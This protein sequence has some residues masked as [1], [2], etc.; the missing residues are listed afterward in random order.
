MRIQFAS[1]AG[2]SPECHTENDLAARAAGDGGDEEDAVAFFDGAGF[3]AK[4]ANV[5][6]V[7]IDVEEL[8][9][10]AAVIA[11]VAREIREARSELRENFGDGGGATIDFWRAVSEA[12][13]RGG[14]FY[15]DWHVQLS[16]C[17]DNFAIPFLRIF[18]SVQQGCGASN[19]DFICR[20]LRRVADLEALRMLQFEAE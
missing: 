10:L 13:E 14:D 4:E 8:A 18:E 3:A 12:A 2:I 7:E 19:V 1:G 15:C 11:D 17:L 20:Q 6:F 9:D 5:F 16:S